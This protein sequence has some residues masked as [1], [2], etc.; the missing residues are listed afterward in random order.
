V[1]GAARVPSAGEVRQA[2]ERV[3]AREE[4]APP[5]AEVPSFVQRVQELWTWAG[6]VARGWLRSLAVMH[7]ENPVL[8]WVLMGWMVVT[9]VAILVHIAYTAVAAW[10]VRDRGGAPRPTAAAAAAP[11]PPDTA[12]AWDAE[13]RRAAAEGRLRDAAVALYQA[14][15]L[16]LDA[17]GV[18][19]REQAKTPGE[20]RREARRDPVAGPAFTAF[21]RQF[22]P[23]A[24]GGRPI[25]GAGYERLRG[26][27]AEAAGHG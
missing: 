23:V 19:R 13:A 15:V 11:P 7:G 12:E 8:F 26:A 1:Q 18:V 27:A 25:D 2:L 24:F 5:P 16:R 3:Y 21:L 6:E 22:E 9:L 20:Y 10:R 14:V 4:L 17:R